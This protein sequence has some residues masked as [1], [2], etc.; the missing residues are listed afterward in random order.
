MARAVLQIKSLKATVQSLQLAG[1]QAT[2]AETASLRAKVAQLEGVLK[3]G[4]GRWCLCQPFT[5]DVAM[6]HQPQPWV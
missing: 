3:V 1:S 6:L 4:A 2:E 5:Q